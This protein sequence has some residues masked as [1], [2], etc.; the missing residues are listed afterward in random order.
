[1]EKIFELAS[2]LGGFAGLACAA[3]IWYLGREIVS[4]KEEV[5]AESR[6]TREALDRMT[7]M[8][9]MHLIASPHVST[10]MKTQ[11]GEQLREVEEVQK[12]K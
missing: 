7:R 4:L 11:L 10:D 8:E 1:M 9:L 2:T 5:I 12:L 3:I 6:R